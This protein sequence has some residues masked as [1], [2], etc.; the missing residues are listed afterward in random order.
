MTHLTSM[1]WTDADAP[2]PDGVQ[3]REVV[4]SSGTDALM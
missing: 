4:S 2:S 3:T 1:N